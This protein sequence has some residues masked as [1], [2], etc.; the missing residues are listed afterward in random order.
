MLT[1]YA[2]WFRL[3]SPL[4]P[5]FCSCVPMYWSTEI[6]PAEIRAGARREQ[7]VEGARQHAREAR[8]AGPLAG[9]GHVLDV[10]VVDALQQQQVGHVRFERVLKA[11]RPQRP[12]RGIVAGRRPVV[13]AA[14]HAVRPTQH[15]KPLDPADVTGGIGSIRVQHRQQRRARSHGFEQQAARETEI[16]LHHGVLGGSRCGRNVDR[17]ASRGAGAPRLGHY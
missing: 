5:C 6:P 13:D 1:T 4:Y 15:V 10:F 7:L 2:P 11:H 17:S 3:T 16:A 9:A 8:V 14:Q 12:A